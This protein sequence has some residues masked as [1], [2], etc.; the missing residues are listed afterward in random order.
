MRDLPYWLQGELVELMGNKDRYKVARLIDKYP[1]ALDVLKKMAY[2]DRHQRAVEEVV[3]AVTYK[4]EKQGDYKALAEY[5]ADAMT[6][7]IP[8]IRKNA[9]DE[10]RETI[11]KLEFLP[12][13]RKSAFENHIISALGKSILEGDS[14]AIVIC[15]FEIQ[16]DLLFVSDISRLAKKAF[17]HA[18]ENGLD[19]WKLFSN[20]RRYLKSD[21]VKRDFELYSG[22][23]DIDLYH[24][25]TKLVGNVSIET[26]E[27][28][29]H[30]PFVRTI[31]IGLML[32]ESAQDCSEKLKILVSMGKRK[33]I[34]AITKGIM[35]FLQ[36]AEFM[37]Q[38][39]ENTPDYERAIKECAGIMEL[40]KAREQKLSEA[41]EA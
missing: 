24:L 16:N 5:L 25:F 7:R 3:W 35:G 13:R 37:K 8:E 28:E 10:I 40:V 4:L 30:M 19:L 38:T 23:P 18:I 33:T 32:P 17:I 41:H 12:A 11:K 21:R 22:K 20:V 34:A 26:T 9:K 27:P 39:G 29:Q 2:N 6:G 31:L 15:T 1:A 14:V 36:S